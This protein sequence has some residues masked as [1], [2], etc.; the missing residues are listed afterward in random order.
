MAE[1]SLPVVLV[2]VAK[3]QLPAEVSL[4]AVSLLA[5]TMFFCF[6]L[7]SLRIL[8]APLQLLPSIRCPGTLSGSISL[9]FVTFIDN[10][11]FL[12][13]KND[14]TLHIIL[15]IKRKMVRVCFDCF[16]VR[17]SMYRSAAIPDAEFILVRSSYLENFARFCVVDNG[18]NAANNEAPFLGISLQLYIDRSYELVSHVI[19]WSCFCHAVILTC[20]NFNKFSILLKIEINI[21]VSGTSRANEKL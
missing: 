1:L 16:I 20:S 21:R 8:F 18:S 10:F 15:V 3:L 19:S 2:H 17:E 12:F 9:K 7:V 11:C 13:E 14:V 4:P 6:V 5:A